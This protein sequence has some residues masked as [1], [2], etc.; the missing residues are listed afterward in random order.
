MTLWT[1][2]RS[3]R[4]RSA[5]TILLS[6][7]LFAHDGVQADQG[8]ENWCPLADAKELDGKRRIALL[9]GVGEYKNKRINSLA[10]PPEDVK[11]MFHLLTGEDGYNFPKENVC[12]LLNRNATL[13]R[14]KKMFD[15]ALVKRIRK[16]SD[17]A[18]L[19]FAGHGSEVCDENQDETGDTD[20]TLMFYDA[21]TASGGELIDD[22]LNTMLAKLNK[23]TKHIS[24]ILDSCTSASATRGYNTYVTRYF[25]PAKKLCKQRQGASGKGDGSQGWI[26]KS[27]PDIAVLSAA[28]DGKAALEVDGAGVFTR[29]IVEILSEANEPL[30][31]GQVERRVRP[32]V[33][34]TS[35]QVPY[36]QGDLDRI[37]FDNQKRKRP[38]GWEITDVGPPIRLSGPP[39]PGISEGTELRIYGGSLEGR[40]IGDP[41]KSKGTVVLDTVTGLN[42]TAHLLQTA[43]GSKL[44]LGDLAVIT[45]LGDKFLRVSVRLRPQQEPGGITTQIAKRIRE[46][47]R[48]DQEAKMLVV[49]T[50]GPGDFEI[51]MPSRT[52]L[53]LRGA[54]GQIRR[55]FDLQKPH[56]MRELTKNLWRHARQKALLAL[57]GEGGDDFKDNETLKVQ[58]VPANAPNHCARGKWEQAKPNQQQIVPLCYKFNVKVTLDEDATVEKVLVGA[59]LFSSDGT[60]IGLPEDGSKAAIGPGQSWIFTSEKGGMNIRGTLPLDI[61]DHIVAFATMPSNPVRWHLLSD[62]AQTRSA[63]L[64]A[65]GPLHRSIDRYLQYKAR[66]LEGEEPMSE[67][68][69]VWTLSALT[70]KVTANAGFLEP[71]E[72]R[73]GL[74]TKREYT[75]PQFDIRPYLPDDVDSALYKVLVKANELAY[76]SVNPSDGIPYKQ[77]P[78]AKA[79]DEENLQVG[80]DCSRAIWFA[81]TRSGLPYNGENEYLHTARM[82][83]SNSLLSQQFLSCDAQ[84]LQLGDVLVY[85]DEERKVGHTVMVIDPDKRIAWGSHGWDGESR[86]GIP[87]DTGVEYQKIK[88]KPDWKRWDSKRM[89]RK[90]CWRY[91]R[92]AQEALKPRGRPGIKALR[93]ACSKKHQCGLAFLTPAPE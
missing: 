41:A 69:T 34:S 85:R 53:A 91:R 39:L 87:A 22:D 15:N 82:V 50:E 9:V 30:T 86:F 37:V 60:V 17:V 90:A 10:G 36:F 24:V 67:D 57:R 21:R 27:M 56:I 83:G 14:F 92:F 81:F 65:K 70:A 79:T 7:H 18:V 23:K 33:R 63:D 47:V 61:E 59:L 48:N 72:S 93:G 76:K 51:E 80:I 40:D 35:F 84:E 43:P 12:V 71:T 54:H 19:Y 25:P 32:R 6:L 75:I 58:L 46:A 45:R 5:L 74:P 77:H 52:E 78:W 89:E 16:P 62:N 88:Y 44:N 38:I 13:Q 3:H 42:A 55:V 20:Q 64:S 28:E 26:P 2:R 31:Y 1:E 66:G 8:L 73:S 49:L 29:A 68:D 4:L 11:Q